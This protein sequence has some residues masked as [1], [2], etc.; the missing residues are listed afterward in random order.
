MKAKQNNLSPRNLLYYTGNDIVSLISGDNIKSFNNERYIKKILSYNELMYFIQSGNKSFIP[1]LFW[2]C[3][4]SVYKI[5][6]QK[7]LKDSFSPVLFC[8]EVQKIELQLKNQSYLIEALT[9][10]ENHTYFCRS[11]IENEYIH[12][13]ACDNQQALDNVIT[14]IEKLPDVSKINQSALTYNLLLKSISQYFSLDYLKL[15]VKK[16]HDG[17]PAIYYNNNLLNISFSVS[18]DDNFVSFVFLKK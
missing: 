4:E 11:I 7:G 14:Y 12:T 10:H 2:S 9:Q 5:L 3:K 1:P 16:D 15:S 8:V 18:H 13:C 17:A 6:L